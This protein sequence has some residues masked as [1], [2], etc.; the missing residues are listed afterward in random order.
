MLRR[1]LVSFA[2][3]VFAAAGLLPV[4]SPVFAY[5]IDGQLD[6]EYGAP[7]LVQTLQTELNQGQI[8]GDN[9]LGNLVFANGS[10]LDAAWA[11]IS[12][13]TL[14]LFVGGNLALVLNQQGNGTI[15]GS[16]GPA[17]SFRPHPATSAAGSPTRPRSDSGKN[18]TG[19]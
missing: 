5:T 6:P 17:S 9:N 2:A 1:R 3:V 14:H 10:E 15:A 7:T 11:S 19:C 4:A 8:T 12:G 16:S 18:S 13:D